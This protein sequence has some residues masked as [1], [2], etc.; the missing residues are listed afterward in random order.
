M[1]GASILAFSDF[2]LPL[3][4]TV[5]FLSHWLLSNV[6]I[7]ESMDREGGEGEREMTPLSSIQ[8]KNIGRA[9]DRTSDVLF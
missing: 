3:L 6:T 7:A 9:V 2:L 8:G 4:H 5:F 1:A